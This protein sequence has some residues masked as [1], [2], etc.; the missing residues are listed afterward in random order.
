MEWKIFKLVMMEFLI[1]EVWSHLTSKVGATC[2]ALHNKGNQTVKK[3]FYFIATSNMSRG[4]EV[5][6]A[7]QCEGNYYTYRL[8]TISLEY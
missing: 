4:I 2:I 6:C 1:G 5:M 8:P 3:N 7:Q